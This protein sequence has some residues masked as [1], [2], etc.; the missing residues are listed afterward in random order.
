MS[1]YTVQCNDGY[2]T[3]S[4]TVEA[5]FVEEHNGHL[6]FYGSEGKFASQVVAIF[7]SKVWFYTKKEKSD[8]RSL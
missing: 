5:D 6:K 1:R 8:E 3:N 2:S 7:S 4:V